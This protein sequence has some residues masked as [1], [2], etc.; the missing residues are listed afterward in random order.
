MRK[1]ARRPTL[2]PTIERLIQHSHGRVSSER[3]P[4]RLWS[5]KGVP[6]GQCPVKEAAVLLLVA[7]SLAASGS[8][9][10]L[11]LASTVH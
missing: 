5:P 1:P 6:N 4:Q 3:S 11:T 9:A 8:R 2:K 7:A 10:A